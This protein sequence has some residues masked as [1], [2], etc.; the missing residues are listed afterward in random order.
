MLTFYEYF[1]VNEA[2]IT[3]KPK[4]AIW[5][6]SNF[7]FNI[8]GDACQKSCNCYDAPIQREPY[9]LYGKGKPFQDGVERCYKVEFESQQLDSGDD[10]YVTFYRGKSVNQSGLNMPL[11]VFRGITYAVQEYIR[12]RKPSRI[13]WYASEKENINPVFNRKVNPDARAKI[14]RSWFL[15]N[16]F[17]DYVEYDS[18]NWAR[19]DVYEDTYVN[20]LGYAE[21][22]A[23]ISISSS[24]RA[25]RQAAD[26]MR[27]ENAKAMYR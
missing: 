18:E 19:R 6:D 13:G 23:D 20:R 22:P 9:N 5:V 26:K 21:I 17:P 27:I 16:F 15:E 14:Y 10:V 24:L 7:F 1:Q 3:S 8:E 25:K 11:E 12:S 4:D 2:M